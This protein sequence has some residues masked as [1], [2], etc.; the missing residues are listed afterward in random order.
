M[1]KK[2]VYGVGIV[3]TKYLTKINYKH[4][5][6]YDAWTN[7][8]K[9]CFSEK[10][11]SQRPTYKD[12]TCCNEWLLYENFYEWLHSQENFD[13]WLNGSFTLEKDI[14][15]KGNKVYSP[16]TCCLVPQNVNKLFTKRD[17]TRG[18]LLIGVSKRKDKF[19][20]K[21]CN[22]ITNK[23]DFLGA[24][25]TQEEAFNVYKIYKEKIIKQIAQEE[26]DKGNITKKC[27]E[28]MMKYEVEITD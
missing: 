6:E 16:E 22:P 23:R 11:K 13:K 17:A 1:V 3:G 28:A 26:Y 9:R 18:D 21:C 10:F 4:L 19:I 24:Y 12:T 5:K 25:D 14:I 7:M 15:V 20:T 27:Y 2:L 8:L